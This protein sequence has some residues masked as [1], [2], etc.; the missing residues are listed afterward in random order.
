MRTSIPCAVLVEVFSASRTITPAGLVR[1]R[2]EPA[3]C[4]WRTRCPLAL[5]L[6][7]H[8]LGEPKPLADCG[9]LTS[10]LI[11][12]IRCLEKTR[13]KPQALILC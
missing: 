5:A 12:Q 13:G 6:C 10:H 3:A 4:R 8:S 11:S 2:R 7:S 1:S 9:F